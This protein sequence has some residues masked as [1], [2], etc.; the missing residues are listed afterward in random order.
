M[1]GNEDQ[2]LCPICKGP[3][4]AEGIHVSL[5]TDF[6]VVDGRVIKLGSSLAPLL[7]ILM[8]NAYAFVSTDDLNQA[9]YGDKWPDTSVIYMHVRALRKILEG[10]KWQV[11]TRR[12]SVHGK[13]DGEK[14]GYMLSREAHVTID[15]EKLAAC[16]MAL[17]DMGVS[18][19]ELPALMETIYP[20]LNKEK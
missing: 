19:A 5:E 8:R 7:Y 11:S 15:T 17:L 2:A 9:I 16:S 3:V 14:T 20:L 4:M 18:E 12:A 1:S 13:D 6:A 10:T